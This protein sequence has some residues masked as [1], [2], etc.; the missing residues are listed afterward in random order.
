VSHDILQANPSV[1]KKEQINAADSLLCSGNFNKKS[2]NKKMK[3]KQ[4]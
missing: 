1:K 3:A 4:R 2:K